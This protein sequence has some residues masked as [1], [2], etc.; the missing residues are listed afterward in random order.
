M[1]PLLLSLLGVGL[2]ASTFVRFNL[3]VGI[4]SH[5][6]TLIIFTFGMAGKASTCIVLVHARPCRFHTLT[7]L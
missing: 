5:S 2:K 1:A 6:S 7:K 4:G 3:M